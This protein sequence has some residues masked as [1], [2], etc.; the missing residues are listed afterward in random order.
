MFFFIFLFKVLGVKYFL[1][2]RGEYVGGFV[3]S[4]GFIGY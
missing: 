1:S 4:E 3:N 2:I